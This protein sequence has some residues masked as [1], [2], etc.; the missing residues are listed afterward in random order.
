MPA[1]S[2]YRPLEDALVVAFVYDLHRRNSGFLRGFLLHP[3]A[4]RPSLPD[5]DRPH[6]TPPSIRPGSFPGVRDSLM[7]L[8]GGK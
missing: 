8:L 7:A 6:R 2:K 3:P 4:Y 5:L 1:I